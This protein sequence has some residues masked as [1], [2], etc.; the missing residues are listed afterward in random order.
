MLGGMTITYEWRGDFENAA[1]NALHAE[2]FDHPILE[3]DWRTQVE[4]HSLGWV[5]AREADQ[6][7]GFVNVAWDGS[8]HAFL[9]DAIV[10]ERVRRQGIGTQLVAVAVAEARAAGC[11]WLH[12]DFEEHLR[13]FYF[14]SCGF[15][16]TPAGVIAL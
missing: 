8:I 15:T 5:C 16:P 6:L 13:S 14:D 10:S 4:R 2:A 7:V 12:V 9:I 11:E 3:D 1:V